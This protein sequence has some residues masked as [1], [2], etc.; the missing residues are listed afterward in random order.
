MR[1]KWVFF[2]CAVSLLA[3]FILQNV[4]VV[5]VRFMLWQVEMSRALLLLAVFGLGVGAGWL[6]ALGRRLNPGET[7]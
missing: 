3:I 1:W 6:L 5:E 2:A 7:R 4:K